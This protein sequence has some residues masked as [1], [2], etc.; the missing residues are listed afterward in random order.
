MSFADLASLEASEWSP[1][2]A[3]PSRWQSQVH[4][5]NTLSIWPAGTV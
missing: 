2:S 5:W 4:S 1:L 3:F